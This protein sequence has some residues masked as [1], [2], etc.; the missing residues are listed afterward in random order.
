[1]QSVSSRIW[2][3]VAV[4]ISYDDNHYTTGTSSLVSYS[5]G[6][7]VNVVNCIIVVNEFEL[8]T[9]YCIYFWTNTHGKR[10]KPLIL[11]R[12]VKLHNNSSSS[13][14]ALA[15]NKPKTLYSIDP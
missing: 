11:E 2:T 9:H 7:V 1:M 14:I 5:E 15:L 6:V 12:S 3:H 13:R 10:K 4:S 8:Q